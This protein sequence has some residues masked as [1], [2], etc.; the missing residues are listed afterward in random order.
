MFPQAPKRYWEETQ[1]PSKKDGVGEE[2]CDGAKQENQTEDKAKK[3]PN[4]WRK[5]KKEKAAGRFISGV[6]IPLFHCRKIL[7]SSEH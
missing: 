6:C 5:K 4:E 1:T 7:L 3:R 2:L